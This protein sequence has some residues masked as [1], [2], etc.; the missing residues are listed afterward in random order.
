[1]KQVVYSDSDIKVILEQIR[2][3]PDNLTNAFAESGKILKRASKSVSMKYY[4]SLKMRPDF[5]AITLGSK[6]GFTHNVKNT[7]RNKGVFPTERKLN[8]PLWLIQTFLELNDEER[9]LVVKV[10]TVQ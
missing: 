7:P 8:R 1:M 2:L 9:S 4:T 6:K 10:L 5:R 3:Y